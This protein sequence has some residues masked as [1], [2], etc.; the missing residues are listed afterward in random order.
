MTSTVLSGTNPTPSLLNADAFLNVFSHIKDAK[1]FTALGQTCIVLHRLSLSIPVIARCSLPSRRFLLRSVL[2]SDLNLHVASLYAQRAVL[3]AS[4]PPILYRNPNLYT[5]IKKLETINEQLQEI[6]PICSYPPPN[7]P[8][9]DFYLLFK[10]VCLDLNVSLNDRDFMHC[11]FSIQELCTVFFSFVWKNAYSDVLV[12]F[13]EQPVSAITIESFC[14]KVE[15]LYI[16]SQKKDLFDTETELR[17]CL[18]VKKGRDF[19]DF[20]KQLQS[21]DQKQIE[22][23]IKEKKTRLR[24]IKAKLWEELYLLEGSQGSI[25]KANQL[26]SQTLALRNQAH[27]T[28][29]E[30]SENPNCLCNKV[31]QWKDLFIAANKRF[32]AAREECL[33]LTLRQSTLIHRDAYGKI[34]GGKLHEIEADIKKVRESVLE[35]LSLRARFYFE[36]DRDI[37]A[38]NCKMRYKVLRRIIAQYSPHKIRDSSW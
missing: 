2:N 19:S 28:Y 20:A 16:F 5:K 4:I 36:L 29:R 15:D 26:M 38:D 32:C 7:D 1:S 13:S 14:Q 8:V 17:I 24:T 31:E 3:E 27:F 6:R 18:K 34:I 33:R 12:A 22:R 10:K 11:V 25:Q 9:K 30:A 37:N 21:V 23:E 35:E